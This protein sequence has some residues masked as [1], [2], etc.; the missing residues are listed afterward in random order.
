MLLWLHLLKYLNYCIKI[1]IPQ[2]ICLIFSFIPFQTSILEILYILPNFKCLAEESLLIK[3]F[4]KEN[5]ALQIKQPFFILN[6]FFDNMKVRPLFYV[7]LFFYSVLIHLFCKQKINALITTKPF[8][9]STFAFI[10]LFFTHFGQ[11]VPPIPRFTG[12]QQE[13]IPPKWWPS[14]F[15]TLSIKSLTLLDVNMLILHCSIYLQLHNINNNIFF[16][17]FVWYQMEY[18]TAFVV[19]T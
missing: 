8:V 18:F 5:H 3:S 11:G 13:Y 14:D 15:V 6:H 4:Y 12:Q 19:F 17:C 9:T 1:F 2:L 16:K 7:S 10:K